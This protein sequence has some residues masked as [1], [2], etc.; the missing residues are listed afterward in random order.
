MVA[1]CAARSFPLISVAT[2]NIRNMRALDRASLWPLRRRKL[3]SAME[4]IDADIWGLQEVYAAQSRWLA[5]NVFNRSGDKGR[6]EYCGVGRNRNGGGEMC[7]IWVRT[8]QLEI[9]ASTTRWFGATPDLPGTKLP[10]ANFPRCAN[11]AQVRWK[12]QPTQIITVANTHL[13]GS[14][15]K[16]RADSISQLAEWLEA[17]I[18]SQPTLVMGDFNCTLEHPEIQPLLT[19]GLKPVLSPSDGPTSHDY[20][21]NPQPRQIDHIFVSAHWRVNASAIAREAGLA[22]DHWPVTSK[23]SVNE[24]L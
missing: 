18:I 23:L 7:P 10:G 6:W 9:V 15:P 22:S 4:A 20:G 2:Y 12:A 17:T 14:S 24:M 1:D 19:L 3:A 13:D 8:T 16:R 5:A 11:L 21:K